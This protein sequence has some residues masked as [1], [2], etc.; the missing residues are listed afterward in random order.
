M[1]LWKTAIYRDWRTHLK[2]ITSLCTF[3]SHA[4]HCISLCVS[5]LA[6]QSITYL[7]FGF[8]YIFD[9]CCPCLIVCNWLGHVNSLVLQNSESSVR[10]KILKLRRNFSFSIGILRNLNFQTPIPTL[11]TF[12]LHTHLH[13]PYWH[14]LVTSFNSFS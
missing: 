10:H 2:I 14:S 5:L 8:F 6:C 4:C 13:Q 11:C 7:F 12:P 9:H 3:K 1:E